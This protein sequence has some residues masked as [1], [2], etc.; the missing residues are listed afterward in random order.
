MNVGVRE[1][2]ALARG[3]LLALRGRKV[4][5]EVIVCPPFVALSE[6][7]KVVAHSAVGLGAQ[8][9]FWEDHGA[10]TGEISGR[11]L[12]E[13]GVQAVLIGHSERR[14][15]LGETDEMIHKKIIQALANQ[16]IPIMCVG[17]TKEEFATGKS[18]ECVRTQLMEA[19]GHVRVRGH[20]RLI[21]AYEPIFAI[22]TGESA[23]IEHVLMMHEAI[24]GIMTE[25]LPVLSSSHVQVL[26]GGSVDGANA[27]QLLRESQ[28]DGVLIGNASIK[29]TQVTEMIAAAS[30]VLEGQV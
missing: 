16:L 11:M 9:L 4:I 29:L 12:T 20:E 10:F 27:Y 14:V 23:T 19:F 2:V 18:Q 13:L 21:V 24:R 17:E 30:E 15:H 3:T 6:V 28:V 8:N 22:G 26:Y 1:S 25:L 7:R 5:P